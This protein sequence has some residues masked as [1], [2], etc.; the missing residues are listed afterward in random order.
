MILEISLLAAIV[1]VLILIWKFLD[2]FPMVS[3]REEPVSQVDQ[4]LAEVRER[5]RYVNKNRPRRI[6]ININK[7]KD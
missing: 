4:K 7:Y 3:E 2:L 6:N 1:V 5:L